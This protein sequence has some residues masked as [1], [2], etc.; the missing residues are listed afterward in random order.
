M[1]SEFAIKT[2]HMSLL[3]DN[4]KI[5]QKET[6]KLFSCDYDHYNHYNMVKCRR[7]VNFEEIDTEPS[8]GKNG[9]V[10]LLWG[11]FKEYIKQSI[12]MTVSRKSNSHSVDICKLIKKSIMEKKSQGEKLIK[13]LIFLKLPS[14]YEALTRRKE[15]KEAESIVLKNKV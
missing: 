6:P 10:W 3:H 11:I 14:A 1:Y 8:T 4:D 7:N 15:T 5:I 13:T 9:G 12:I 2:R